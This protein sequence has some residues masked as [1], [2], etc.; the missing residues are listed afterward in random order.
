MFAVSTRSTELIVKNSLWCDENPTII[1]IYI[2]AF[3]N[4][5]LDSQVFINIASSAL[6]SVSHLLCTLTLGLCVLAGTGWW[7]RC[8]VVWNAAWGSAFPD[9]L[10]AWV[11]DF[12]LFG[13]FR[14]WSAS[15]AFMQDFSYTQ[16]QF[17][18]LR[19]FIMQTKMLWVRMVKRFQFRNAF[20]IWTYMLMESLHTLLKINWADKI[21]TCCMFTLLHQNHSETLDKVLG[22][23]L[24]LDREKV[25][26]V[27]P[28]A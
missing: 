27:F 21:L 2:F 14:S 24:P 19:P 26:V 18:S 5:I 16:T 13:F 7:R 10:C 17:G 6:F 22:L 11:V 23:G 8:S 28:K 12:Y 3:D 9:C 20:L 4:C 1:T 25:S 15:N